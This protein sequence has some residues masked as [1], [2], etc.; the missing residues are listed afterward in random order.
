MREADCLHFLD[1]N[2]DSVVLLIGEGWGHTTHSLSRLCKNVMVKHGGSQ[3]EI[4]AFVA[5]KEFDA[6]IVQDP[7]FLRSRSAW[8]EILS[9]SLKSGGTLY[10][11]MEK[12]VSFR[13]AKNLM[14]RLGLHDVRYFI[15]LPS[16]RLPLFFLPLY[17]MNAMRYFFHNLFYLVATVPPEKRGKYKFAIDI[18]SL[19]AKMLP[20][21]F[22]VLLLRLAFLS[23]TIIAK[24]V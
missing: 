4:E 23:K 14:R 7:P 10:I 20:V 3:E 6:I 2:S 24:K 21:R 13:L 18:A 17:N 1:L 12:G 11:A 15:V 16:H 22:L 5:R 8:Y 9:R 19:V